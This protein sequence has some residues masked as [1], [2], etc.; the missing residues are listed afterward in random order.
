MFFL[1][2]FFQFNI[3]LTI[4]HTKGKPEAVSQKEQK[5]QRD[6]K[7]SSQNHKH[8]INKLKCKVVKTKMILHMKTQ[9]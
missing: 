7:I 8:V 5:G 1:H 2:I 9:R 4:L 3:P 6:N